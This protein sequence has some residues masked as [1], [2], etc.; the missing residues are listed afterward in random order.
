MGPLIAIYIGCYISRELLQRKVGFFSITDIVTC[1]EAI[2]PR[3]IKVI[4]G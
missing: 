3:L 2:G 1:Q 4:L